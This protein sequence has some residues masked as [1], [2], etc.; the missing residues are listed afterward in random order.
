MPYNNEQYYTQSLW[1]DND[2]DSKID[3]WLFGYIDI[4]L[5]YEHM[6][7]Q[8]Y[9]DSWQEYTLWQDLRVDWS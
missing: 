6:I 1:Y 8:S 3:K 4:P 5:V 7:H 9:R 2:F